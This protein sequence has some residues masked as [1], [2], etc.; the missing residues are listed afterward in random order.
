MS[1][2]DYM[3]LIPLFFISLVL[4]RY[5]IPWQSRRAHEVNALDLGKPTLPKVEPQRLVVEIRTTPLPPEE[6]WQQ[7]GQQRERQQGAH[8]LYK[9]GAAE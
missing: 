2:I 6:H 3:Q 1:W 9:N 5:L 7:P 4:A 8:Y